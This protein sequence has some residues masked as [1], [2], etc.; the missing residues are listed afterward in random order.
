M[1][2]ERPLTIRET[3]AHAGHQRADR[4][5]LVQAQGAPNPA[6]P[7]RQQA[8]R[9]PHPLGALRGMAGRGGEAH[10]RLILQVPGNGSARDYKNRWKSQQGR[11]IAGHRQRSRAL[12]T[13]GIAPFR[14]P[15]KFS[16]RKPAM[17]RVR[18]TGAALPAKNLLLC[19]GEGK[20]KQRTKG[21]P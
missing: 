7:Q 9:H 17:P 11:A 2:Y 5:L 13:R 19:N 4:A 18:R 21:R 3:A 10:Q 14:E 12:R 20:F 6:P 15:A 8:P 16:E 1:S